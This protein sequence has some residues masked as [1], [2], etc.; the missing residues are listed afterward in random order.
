MRDHPQRGDKKKLVDLA[1]EN[2]EIWIGASRAA[3]CARMEAR[4]STE[5]LSLPGPPSV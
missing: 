3:R 4:R 2:A 5:V 1:V